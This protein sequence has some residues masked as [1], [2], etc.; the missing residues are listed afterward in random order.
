MISDSPSLRLHKGKATSSKAVSSVDEREY[1][2]VNEFL[3]LKKFIS[4]LLIVTH[5]Q[6]YSNPPIMGPGIIYN[7]DINN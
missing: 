7:N 6:S 2:D 4:L 1:D 5:T 3:A